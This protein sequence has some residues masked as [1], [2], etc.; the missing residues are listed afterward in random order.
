VTRAQ[1]RDSKIKPHLTCW[2]H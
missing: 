2:A 1:K